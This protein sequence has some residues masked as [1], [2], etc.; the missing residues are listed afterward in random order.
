MPSTNPYESPQQPSVDTFRQYGITFDQIE[1]PPQIVRASF[2]RGTIVGQY[3]ASGMV[4]LFGL[5]IATLFT[6]TM[7]TPSNM[8]AAMAA[9]F[10]AALLVYMIGR[11]DY[12][13][14]ELD[15]TTIRAKHLYSGQ[16]TER[17]LTSI[18]EL[19]TAVLQMQT[20]TNAL[21][22]AW[23]GRVRGVKIFFQN[24]PAPVFVSR[25]DPKMANAKE[26]MEAIVYRMA[27]IGPIDAE[28][29]QFQGSPL[30]KRIFWK[31][32]AV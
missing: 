22:N 12:M 24:D 2:G 19:E 16:I 27:Q 32:A 11:H 14:V 20:L 23:V 25:A 10:V 6:F 18:R 17:P 1:P 7:P 4:S 30:V 29:V 8:A 26:L 15:G 9:L 13:W 3:A 21:V 5:A 31:K 28:I